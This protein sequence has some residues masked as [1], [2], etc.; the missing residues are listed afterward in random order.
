MITLQDKLSEFNINNFDVK[1]HD[2]I[3]LESFCSMCF[4]GAEKHKIDKLSSD[5]LEFLQ[6]NPQYCSGNHS[7]S[8]YFKC[9]KCN[10]IIDILNIHNTHNIHNI[11]NTYTVYVIEGY[12]GNLN[13]VGD[14]MLHEV[15]DEKYY[16]SCE[17]Q[18]IKN[19]IE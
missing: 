14:E 3:F 19:I 11:H 2:F 10:I 9:N 13:S 15:N 17:E 1:N 4:N 12:S 8:N 6:N 18:I 7:R 5:L 16:L